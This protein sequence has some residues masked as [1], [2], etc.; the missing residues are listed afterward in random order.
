MLGI[1]ANFPEAVHKTTYFSTSISCNTLQ[2]TLIAALVRLN[3]ETFN[4]EVISNP[5]VPQCEVRFE[6]GIAEADNFNYLDNEEANR[7]LVTA[8]AKPFQTMDFLCAVRYHKTQEDKR[9]HLRFDYYMLRFT[10]N[11]GTLQVQAFH[12]RGPRHTSPEDIIDSVT[13]KINE[14]S[15]KKVLRPLISP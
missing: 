4:L 13:N 10:L 3:N 8:H 2:K 7:L 12:E 14:I 6:F 5:S 9:T 11:E 1:Y 15:T